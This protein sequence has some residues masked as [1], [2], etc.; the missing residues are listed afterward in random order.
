SIPLI[1]INSKPAK[2]IGGIFISLAIVFFFFHY[3]LIIIQSRDEY[4]SGGG[5]TLAQF[6]YHL[7][8]SLIVIAM[9]YVTYL[10]YNVLFKGYKFLSTFTLWPFIVTI[11]IILS[12]ELDH[13]WILSIGKNNIVTA[14]ILEK[15]HRMPYT[16]LWTGF[17]ANTTLIGTI[18][19]SQQLRQ[20]S[21]FI[22]LVALIS[23]AYFK[24]LKFESTPKSKKYHKD[25]K[26]Y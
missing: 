19:N 1:F 3:T 9:A 10:N 14:D 6:Q 8:I 2:L 16:M 4:L 22:I 13:F 21:L 11:L 15:V 18:I 12:I 26:E 24:D 25:T 23:W 5:I 17:A 20:V 7:F